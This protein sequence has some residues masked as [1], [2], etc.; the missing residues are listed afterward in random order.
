[1]PSTTAPTPADSITNPSAGPLRRVAAL[2]YDSLLL[3]A[4]SLAYGFLGVAITVVITGADPQTL[5]P[6]AASPWLF[7]G[8]VITLAL[9]YCVFWRRG[10][11][12][13]G[14]R[15]W[16][17]KL[18]RDT[19]G[20]GGGTIP[21]WREC[22]LRCLVAPPA[23]A[24]AGLGYWWCYFDPKG[25]SLQDRLSATRVVVVPKAGR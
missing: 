12:T 2:V 11:Q 9:F 1:M 7:I 20:D 22:L 17:L 14:M 5:E 3:I 13:L 25:R 10:G 18:E 19:E 24:A 15:A 16:R 4:L 8:W 6:I 21:G 23:L